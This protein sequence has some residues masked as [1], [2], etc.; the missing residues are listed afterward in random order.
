MVQFMQD[1]SKKSQTLEANKD[2]EQSKAQAEEEQPE[3]GADFAAE[4]AQKYEAQ[5]K[6]REAGKKVAESIMNNDWYKNG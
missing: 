4:L 1:V 3:T 2:S 5:Q 6:E